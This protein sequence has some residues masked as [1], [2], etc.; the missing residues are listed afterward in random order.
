MDDVI[1]IEERQG[2]RIV[3]FMRD[4]ID[5]FNI[6]EVLDAINQSIGADS[7]CLLDM[8]KVRFIDSSGLGGVIK[9]QKRF[10]N[11]GGRFGLCN[12]NNHVDSLLRLTQ[13]KKL[14]ECFED[15]PEAIRRL[16]EDPPTEAES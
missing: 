15:Q 7:L 3:T 13:T 6:V 12:L 5:M 8:Q 9:M 10:K 2:V 16:N 1:K 11:G 14:I 4:Q